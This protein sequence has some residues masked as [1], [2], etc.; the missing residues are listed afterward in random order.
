[1]QI[2]DLN[3]SEYKFISSMY[4]L[5]YV[6]NFDIYGQKH[7]LVQGYQVYKNILYQDDKSHLEQVRKSAGKRSRHL[8][9]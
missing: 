5:M 8:S 4:E 6:Y 7:F 2:N 9:L 3:Q 1:M